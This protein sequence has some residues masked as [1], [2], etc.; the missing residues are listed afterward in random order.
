MDGVSVF[1][2]FGRSAGAFWHWWLGE[3][4]GL[5]PAGLAGLFVLRR[6]RLVL[7][8]DGDTLRLL[9]ERSAGQPRRWRSRSIPFDRPADAAAAIGKLRRRSP[10]MPVGIRLPW[11]DCLVRSF[12]IPA[13][14][15]GNLRGILELEIERVTPFRRDEIYFDFIA[16]LSPG[17]DGKLN[18][19]QIL[20]E[21][22]RV[23]PL[24]AELKVNGIEASFIDCW[25]K[26]GSAALPV[27]L[28][29]AGRAGATRP[30]RSA[31][32]VTGALA[33][34]LLALAAG[35]IYLDLDRYQTARDSLYAQIA[36]A[37]REATGLRRAREAAATADATVAQLIERKRQLSPTVAIIEEISRILPD[38]NWLNN[39]RV[40]G[41]T[42]DMNGFAKSAT[43]LVAVFASAAAKPQALI[44]DA[45][46]T[47]PVTFDPG[48]D[49]E[50][51]SLRLKLKKHDLTQAQPNTPDGAAPAAAPSTE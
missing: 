22:S 42:A 51:F 14:A 39:L 12:K 47:A 43:S 17:P 44:G 21:R 38:D 30:R 41:D 10:A 45:Q 20:L 13:Q 31:I 4:S 34:L 6:P 25:N 16:A 18:I 28:L 35:T 37:K 50:Q 29:G 46:L 1:G 48:R 32:G 5:L 8:A 27:D 23:D 9:Q 33:A 2:T 7:W 11:D 15:R 36:L 3:L 19:E 40:E 49:R 26:Q 24:L